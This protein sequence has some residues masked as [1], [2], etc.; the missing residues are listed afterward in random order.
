VARVFGTIRP[1]AVTRTCVGDRTAL[2]NR[3][4]FSDCCAAKPVGAE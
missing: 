1:P 2:K 4:K 3:W